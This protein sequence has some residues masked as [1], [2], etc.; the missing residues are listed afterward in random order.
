MS[1]HAQQPPTAPATA[2]S[3][4]PSLSSAVIVGL[5]GE[6]NEF[7][8]ASLISRVAEARSRG[9]GTVIVRLNTPGG[10]VGPALEI[11]RFLKRTEDLRLIA[12]VDEMAY[13]AGAMIAVACDEI[14]MQP[15]S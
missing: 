10:M 7:T 13:S 14:Y 5:D 11:T 6:I 3:T 12:Y 1:V 9:A 4:Q 8:R 15:G 2:P